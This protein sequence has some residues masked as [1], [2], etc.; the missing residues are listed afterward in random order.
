M[1]CRAGVAW[2]CSG[3]MNR[4]IEKCGVGCEPVTPNMLSTPFFKGDIVTLIVPTGFGNKMYSN[5]LPAL[6]ASSDRIKK[7]VM[8]GGHVLSFGAMTRDDG[9]YDWLPFRCSYVHEYFG[10]QISVN[11]D[12]AFHDIMD[13]FDLSKIECDGYFMDESPEYEVVAET[14]DKKPVVILKK[15]GE[16]YYLITS[17]HELPSKDFIKKFCTGNADITL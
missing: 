14:S 1:K 13:D 5:L 2:E 16:G 4:Y 17:I 12:S 8:K 15:C 3:F 6:R 10:A 7:F 11:H 9:V